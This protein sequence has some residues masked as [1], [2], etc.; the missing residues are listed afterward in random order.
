M[1]GIA[2]SA[3]AVLI[4]HLAAVDG[5]HPG[6]LRRRDVAQPPA[7]RHRRAV[8]HARRAAPRPHRPRHR[9]RARHRPAHRAGPAPRH[10]RAGRRR[11]PRAARR[12]AGLLPRRRAGRGGARRRVRTRRCGCSGRAATAPSSPGSWACRSPSPTTSAARTRC[13][14]SS[15]T[16]GC[17]GRRRCSTQPYALIAASV[18]CAPDDAEAHRLALPSALQFLQLRLGRPGPVPT[19]EEA[20]AYPYTRRGARLRRA[21]A[22]GPGHRLAGDRARRCDGA[23]RADGG[24][25]ADGRHEHPRRR[26]PAALVPP[27][28]RGARPRDRSGDERHD[29]RM[30]SGRQRQLIVRPIRR[31]DAHV[32]V[33]P[34]RFAGRGCPVVRRT[35][36]RSHTPIG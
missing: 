33:G 11:L 22:R 35:S 17:S 8:R 16:G 19:P 21:A 6:R 5:A 23:G 14:R 25:R 27:A 2:S 3:P 20:A 18:L 24:G 9:P 28:G 7:A 34:A 26:G 4:A 10:R 30:I 15:S 31:D 12:A 32:H 13:P 1:P 36:R 29:R